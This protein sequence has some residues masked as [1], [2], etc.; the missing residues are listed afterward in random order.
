MLELLKC[1]QFDLARYIKKN[2]CDVYI[3][4]AGMI[5]KIVIPNFCI[6]FG[7]EKSI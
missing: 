6:Q 7:I 3:Y 1:T 4:G 5:G 2:N